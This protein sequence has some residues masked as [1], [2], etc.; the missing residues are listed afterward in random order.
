MSESRARRLRSRLRAARS[1]D[2]R[3]LPSLAVSRLRL[4]AARAARRSW[5]RS[6]AAP[7]AAQ[8]GPAAA[9]A[10]TTLATST[11]TPS[12][13][14][15][16]ARPLPLVQPL[17][18]P[19]GTVELQPAG[20]TLVSATPWRRSARIVPVLRDFDHPARPLRLEV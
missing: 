2:P 16:R 15:R 6:A 9:R 19:R 5:R 20:N 4:A 18:S 17:L 7:L 12:S 3:S 8:S 1:A 10:P 13:T 14:S 11:P